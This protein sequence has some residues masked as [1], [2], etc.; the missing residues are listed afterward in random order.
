LAGGASNLYADVK[1]VGKLVADIKLSASP[2]LL[3]SQPLTFF[4]LRG[5]SP[6][7]EVC[8][9]RGKMIYGMKRRSGWVEKDGKQADKSGKG[10]KTGG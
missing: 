1:K 8:K 4:L 9:F 2:T 10:W 5:D 6:G 7:K 3:P